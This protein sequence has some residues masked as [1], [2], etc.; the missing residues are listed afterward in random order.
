MGDKQKYK[1][2]LFD[3]KGF[4]ITITMDL[5]TK[6]LKFAEEKVQ[7]SGDYKK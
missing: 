4:Y 3:I 2:T 5:L 7:I 1:F 6:C